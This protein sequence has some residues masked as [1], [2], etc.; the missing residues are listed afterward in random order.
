MNT[1]K[2]YNLLLAGVL[3]VVMLGCAASH[4]GHRLSVAPEAAVLMPDSTHSVRLDLT[5]RVPEKAF[6]RR[7]RLIV[8]PQ[9]MSGDSLIAEC[10][11]L[12]LD[13]P[14]YARKLQ[15]RKDLEGYTDSLS[16]YA[17]PAYTGKTMEIPYRETVA[18]PDSLNDGRI[19][20]GGTTDGCGIC[21]A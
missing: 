12:V 1:K 10:T 8:V 5:V 7:S 9:L 3:P 6:S 19:L 14:V 15:R 16:S 11:P 4:E 18:V 2:T 21:S 17:R 13:A 20:A